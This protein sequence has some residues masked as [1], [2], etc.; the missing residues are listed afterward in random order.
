MLFLDQLP[1]DNGVLEVIFW[2]TSSYSFRLFL[3]RFIVV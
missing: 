1:G 2:R 3:C